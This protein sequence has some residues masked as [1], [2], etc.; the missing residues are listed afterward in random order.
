MNR[1]ARA[2]LPEGLGTKCSRLPALDAQRALQFGLDQTYADSWLQEDSCASVSWQ[3][4]NHKLEE[5]VQS[6]KA[7]LGEVSASFEEH[8]LQQTT[9]PDDIAQASGKM[10]HVVRCILQGIYFSKMCYFSVSN[11]VL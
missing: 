1:R 10:W 11:N 4:A 2:H 9:N 3:S 5:Q 7:K 6:L 8:M